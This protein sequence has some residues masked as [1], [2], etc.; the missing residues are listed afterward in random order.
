MP[1]G[2][3]VQ[4]MF[5]GIAGKYDLLNH[6]LSLGTDFYWWHRM[7]RAAGAA[8]GKRFLDVAAG[9]GD[10]SLALARRGAEVVSSDFTQAMLR[11]GPAKFQARG[12]AG[13]IWASVGAD[14]QR[15]PFAAA[16]F[17]GITICYGIRNVEERAK[18]YREF[19]RVLK[20]QGQLTILEFSRPRFA[21]LRV[22]YDTY[23]LRILPRIGGWISGSRDAYQYLPSSIRSFPDQPALARELEAA[24][25][26][27]VRWTNLTGGIAALHTARKPAAAPGAMLGS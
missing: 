9:T 26:E 23:S 21:W 19:L 13:R 10:S 17:D 16:S 27:G 5:S 7:A 8:P 14:A 1:Q 24:G 22:L 2:K 12:L 20:P 25:F 15:L 6:V 3:Q 18:A 4:A 11:L